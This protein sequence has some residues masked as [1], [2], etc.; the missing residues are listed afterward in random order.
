MRKFIEKQTNCQTKV[1]KTC[2]FMFRKAIGIV[3]ARNF[4]S[5]EESKDAGFFVFHRGDLTLRAQFS[6]PAGLSLTL[7]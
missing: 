2:I 5:M 7:T 3:N 6:N 4:G 1:L